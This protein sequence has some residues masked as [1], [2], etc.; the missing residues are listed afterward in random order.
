[1]P[2]LAQAEKL[3]PL[4][5]ETVIDMSVEGAGRSE[6]F[7]LQP[8]VPIDLPGDWRLV[9]RSNVPIT[10]V[11][12][13]ES[14]SGF[15][16]IDVSAFVT[17]TTTSPWT[18]G[19]GPMVQ[20]PTATGGIESTGKWSAGPTGALVFV[21]NGWINGVVISHLWSVAGASA[22]DPVS[23]TQIELTISYSFSNK[24]YFNANPTV[25][26]DWKLPA[27]AGWTVPVGVDVGR[28]FELGPHELSVQAD[29][30]RNVRRTADDPAW[31]FGVEVAWTR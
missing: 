28:S 2:V 4:A 21:N 26:R 15:G 10:W 27:D 11:R 18:W 19:A 13:G 6:T 3:N 12:G 25:S 17:R 30:Y 23:L 14:A 8:R 7:N 20:T 9:S 1:M 24:W 29:L 16:D 22:R 5:N 31:T